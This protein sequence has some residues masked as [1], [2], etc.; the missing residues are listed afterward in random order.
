VEGRIIYVIFY[1]LDKHGYA[2]VDDDVCEENY[3]E[4]EEN[5]AEVQ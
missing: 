5:L 1:I 2:H 4:K 3:Q